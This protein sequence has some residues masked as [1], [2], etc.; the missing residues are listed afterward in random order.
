MDWII[1]MLLVIL[2]IISAT[3]TLL[4]IPHNFIRNLLRN[5]FKTET[6]GTYVADSM[7]P[8]CS[9]FIMSCII[10]PSGGVMYSI[11]SDCINIC[12]INVLPV[13]GCSV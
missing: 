3:T 10:A 7:H 12:N 9:L 8:S 2:R 13:A 11:A 5:T 4:K 6:A 1:G